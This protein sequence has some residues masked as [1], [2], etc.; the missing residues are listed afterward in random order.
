MNPRIILLTFSPLLRNSHIGMADA[1][2]P[3]TIVVKITQ[4]QNDFAIFHKFTGM[5]S[6]EKISRPTESTDEIFGRVRTSVFEHT[7]LT[8]FDNRV[9]TR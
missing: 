6:N 8:S 9:Y 5:Y 7:E 3:T 4:T 2:K 1:D